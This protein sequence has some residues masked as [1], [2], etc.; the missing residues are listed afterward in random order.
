MAGVAVALRLGGVLGAAALGVR[1][2]WAA[3]VML[4]ERSLAA[5]VESRGAELESSGAGVGGTGVIETAG[6]A[7]TEGVTGV[8]AAC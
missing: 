8:E 6:V 7:A 5:A 3:G 4:L 2:G 1:V